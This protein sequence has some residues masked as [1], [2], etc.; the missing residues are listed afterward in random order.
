MCRECRTCGECKPLEDFFKER[1]GKDGLRSGCK[2]CRKKEYDTWLNRLKINP[3]LV[4]EM[5]EKDRYK[6]LYKRFGMTK[7][8]YNTLFSSQNGCCAICKQHQ[9]EFKRSFA[10]DHCHKTGKIRGLLCGNC[11]TAL[12]LLREDKISLINMMT[13]LEINSNNDL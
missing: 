11:N 1:G 2:V 10:V 3:N 6:K 12:G 5:S 9:S 8:E 4:K 7:E 13:Y